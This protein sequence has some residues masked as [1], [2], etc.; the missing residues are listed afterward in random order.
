MVVELQ[1]FH[2]LKIP[3]INV[4]SSPIPMKTSRKSIR[5]AKCKTRSHDVSMQKLRHVPID[6]PVFQ[7]ERTFNLFHSKWSCSTSILFTEKERPVGFVEIGFCNF[8]FFRLHGKISLSWLKLI[9]FFYRAETGKS[10]KACTWP[11]AFKSPAGLPLG[12]TK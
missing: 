5:K 4:Y 3:S 8:Q 6:L 9:F 11:N 7:R 12:K 1:S 10:A 2:P